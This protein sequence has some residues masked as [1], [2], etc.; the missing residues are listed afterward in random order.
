LA[1]ADKA[2]PPALSDFSQKATGKAVLSHTLQHPLTLF[3]GAVGL[4]GIVSSLVLGPGALAFTALIGGLSLSAGSWIVNYCFRNEHFAAHYIAGLQ[5]SMEQYREQ[6]VDNVGA[7][8]EKFRSADA[9]AQYAELAIVQFK[10]I[11]ADYDNVKTLLDQKFHT[12][13]LTYGRFLGAAEQ[14]YLG[15]LDNLQRVGTI[16]QSISTLDPAEFKQCRP[17]RKK[18]EIENCEEKRVEAI[19]ARQK[20][21][22]E[23]IGRINTLL[24]QNES[25]ITEIEK[26]AA[27]VATLDT[28]GQLAEITPEEA[29]KQLQELAKRVYLYNKNDNIKEEV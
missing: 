21:Y 29:I 1:S 7:L 28:D 22:E 17:K 11:E 5:K 25:A 26:T 8:L 20:L 27:A 13:E 15:V 18:S 3:S 24:A 10:K 16:L 9:T 2:G 23:Q 4:L 14:V 19:E 6:L 12:G